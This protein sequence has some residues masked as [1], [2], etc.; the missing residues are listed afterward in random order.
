MNRSTRGAQWTVF[1]NRHV[2]ELLSYKLTVQS[3]TEMS[4]FALRHI[5]QCTSAMTVQDTMADFMFPDSKNM[6]FHKYVTDFRGTGSKKGQERPGL[7]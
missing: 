1:K 4:V 7:F 3:W 2:F 5:L 6:C